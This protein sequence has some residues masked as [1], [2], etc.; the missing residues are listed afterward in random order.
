MGRPIET[1]G[2]EALVG[3]SMR[4]DF[5]VRA[6]KIAGAFF[7]FAVL[8]HNSDHA[9]RG[10]E[11]VTTDVF[12]IGSLAIILEVGVVALIFGDHRDAALAATLV[13]FSLAVGYVVVHFTPDRGWLSDSFVNG[14][15]ALVSRAAASLEIAGALGLAL[16]GLAAMRAGSVPEQERRSVVAAFRHPIVA[17]MAAG[18][19]AIFL[20]A[21][22]QRYG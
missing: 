10:G 2:R 5:A 11:S 3:P 14:T 22:A 21:V 13:G 9:R 17:L 6:L 1:A 19:L 4:A 15:P 8:F 7:A 20:L 18:N 16:A 12:W